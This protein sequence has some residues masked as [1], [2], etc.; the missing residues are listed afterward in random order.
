MKEIR[1][2]PLLRKM[3]KSMRWNCRC[4]SEKG[5]GRISYIPIESFYSHFLF[6]I[7]ILVIS[8]LIYL[9]I[10]KTY[11]NILFYFINVEFYFFRAMKLRRLASLP[12]PYLYQQQS[13]E[14]DPIPQPVVVLVSGASIIPTCCPLRLSLSALNRP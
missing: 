7:F 3:G 5:A 11:S 12:V 10:T 6:L 9:E 4:E 14:E 13:L 1:L 2:L 8:S